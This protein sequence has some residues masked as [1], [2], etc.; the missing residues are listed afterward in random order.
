MA[1]QRPDAGGF[2]ESALRATGGERRDL[3][4]R[5]G[6]SHRE[7]QGEEEGGEGSVELPRRGAEARSRT[8]GRRRSR[9]GEKGQVEGRFRSGRRQPSRARARPG[10]SARALSAGDA[11]WRTRGRSP[12]GPRPRESG[13]VGWC[14]RRQ[15]RRHCGEDGIRPRVSNGLGNGLKR[16]TSHWHARE[17]GDDGASGDRVVGPVRAG[18]E[19][20]QVGRV[21]RAGLR[22]W[23]KRRGVSARSEGARG[24]GGRP[25]T[26]QA[27]K[28]A[29]LEDDLTKDS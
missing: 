13:G 10:R 24:E 20:E 15:G 19:R 7:T 14:R 25:R 8:T 11:W 18:G 23:G 3:L 28:P 16:S 9:S 21:E 1:R 26:D 22:G 27:V 2:D 6:G 12:G 29:M 4:G 5:K 17:V